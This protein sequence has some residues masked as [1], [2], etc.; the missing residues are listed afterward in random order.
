MRN[1]IEQQTLL[2]LVPSGTFASFA[3]SRARAFRVGVK[4]FV[5][6]TV[7]ELSAPPL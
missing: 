4:K 3:F 7:G 5:V 6:E 2:S 1:P